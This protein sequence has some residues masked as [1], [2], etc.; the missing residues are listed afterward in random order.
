VADD[1]I[2]TSQLSG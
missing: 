2:T 1:V